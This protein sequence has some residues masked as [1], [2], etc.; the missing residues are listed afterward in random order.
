M[1]I[2]PFRFDLNELGGAFGDIGTLLPLSLGLIAISGLDPS[3]LFLTVGLA[4]IAAGIYFRVPTPIQPMKAVASISI[5]AGFSPSV[6]ASS[7]LWMSLI[8]FLAVFSKML[9]FLKRIITKPIVRGI[10]FAVGLLLVKKAFDLLLEPQPIYRNLN[11]VLFFASFILLLAFLRNKRIPSSLVV[12]GLGIVVTI[13]SNPNTKFTLGFHLPQISPPNP[14]DALGALLVLI[15][16]QFLTTIGNAVF[17]AELTARDYYGEAA[18]R[19]NVESLAISMGITNLFIS[20]G[21]GM[22]VCHGS[23]GFTAHYRF[24]ARTGGAN[25]II[26]TFFVLLSLLLGPSLYQI[27]KNFPYPILA[28]LLGYVGL[29]HAL[30]IKKLESVEEIVPAGI[31]SLVLI[32][33]TLLRR[34]IL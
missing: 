34:F 33:L 9:K 15:P 21:G 26:G 20:L 17:A 18:K 29:R 5:A 12:I 23:G 28:V 19:I 16:A 13:L 11:L 22:P 32:S 10:Q 7:G 1:K 8:L 3:F 14:K 27:L 30:F 25:I 2:G 4:Y 24:G 31:A 6:V